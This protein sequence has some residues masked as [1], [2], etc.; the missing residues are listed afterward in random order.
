MSP[1]AN[2]V[3]RLT[4]GPKVAVEEDIPVGKDMHVSLRA[5]GF[6]EAINRR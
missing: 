3:L 4:A 5:Q 1:F 6:V 2:G